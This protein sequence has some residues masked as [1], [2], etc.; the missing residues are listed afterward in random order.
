MDWDLA[1]VD[2]VGEGSE[3]KRERGG[4]FMWLHPAIN[5]HHFIVS[6]LDYV[7]LGHIHST[8]RQKLWSAQNI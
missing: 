7:S 2:D 1:G 3:V 8:K 4:G 6:F 5:Q